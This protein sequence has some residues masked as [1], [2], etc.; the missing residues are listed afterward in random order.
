[1]QLC[2]NIHNMGI[3]AA[4]PMRD[5]A[6]ELQKYLEAC[7]RTQEEIAAAAGVNQSTVHR[8]MNGLGQRR[9]LSR[10]LKRLC[11]YA[12]IETTKPIDA[13]PAR[14]AE[15]MS[16]IKLAWDGTEEHATALARVIRELG[17]LSG[18]S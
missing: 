14:N 5:I 2:I 7:G 4:R 6:R 11:K 12:Q 18:Q 8:A 3:A 10:A 17:R 13:E 15:L 16:A 9:R 1:M